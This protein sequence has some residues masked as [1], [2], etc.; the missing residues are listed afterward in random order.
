MN[1]MRVIEVNE[2]GHRF[3]I[4]TLNDKRNELIESGQDTSF[5]DETLLDVIDAL[6]TRTRESKKQKRK[7]KGE[8]R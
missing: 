4:S 8:E 2:Y 6:T 3:I 7:M 1:E 5:V